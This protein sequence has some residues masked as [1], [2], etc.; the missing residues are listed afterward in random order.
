M[1]YSPEEIFK[2]FINSVF[3]DASLDFFA[4]RATVFLSM[5]MPVSSLFL[6][7][8][9]AGTITKLAECNKAPSINISDHFAIPPE[10]MARLRNEKHFFSEGACN[11]KI[12]TGRETCA[13][14]DVH[15]SIYKIDTSALYIPL[16]FNMLR[17][18]SVTMAVISVGTDNY[19]QEH[20]DVCS[21]LQPVFID[22]FLNILSENTV[23]NA[24]DAP[25]PKGKQEPSKRSRDDAEPFQTF[26][27]ITVNY[28][29]K[30]LNRTNGKISGQDGAAEL[31]GLNPSTL[32]SKIRKYRIDVKGLERE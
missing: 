18:T 10:S 30:A 17:E 29:I 25:L 11:L 7:R 23:D 15:R 14:A 5:M 2:K 13:Y 27:E 26:N 3:S 16:K 8:S 19:T 22:C 6:F 4:K 21:C 1:R 28:I 32:W 24:F 12:F 20:L 9:V 31:L